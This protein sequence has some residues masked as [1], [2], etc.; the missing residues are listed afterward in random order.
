MSQCLTQLSF[1]E[2]IVVIE[3]LYF[4]TVFVYLEEN[5]YFICVGFES[6]CFVL[7]FSLKLTLPLP[8]EMRIWQLYLY[9]RDHLVLTS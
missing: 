6:L 7:F 9:M 2:Y 4:I 3:K 1:S 8:M 5:W